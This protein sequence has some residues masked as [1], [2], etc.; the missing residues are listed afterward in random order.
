M[1]CIGP[2]ACVEISTNQHGPKCVT[3]CL[4]STFDRAILMRAISA[5]GADSISKAL[6]ESANFLI[7]IKFATLVHVDVLSGDLRCILLKPVFEPIER[8]AF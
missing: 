8:S 1:E 6:E 2:E 5:S 4:V 3:N 7:I